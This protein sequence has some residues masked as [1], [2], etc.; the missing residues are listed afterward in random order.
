MPSS[1]DPHD[2]QSSRAQAEAT[3]TQSPSNSPAQGSETPETRRLLHELHVHQVELELQN[4]ELRRANNALDASRARYVDLYNLAPVGYCSVNE[5]GLIVQ[6]NL[7][8]AN[9]LGEAH[10]RL[11]GKRPFTN[12]VFQPDRDNWYL[13]RK[14]L[15][16]S[17]TP[18]TCELRL[19]QVNTGVQGG[20][21]A[22]VWVELSVTLAQDETG[23]RLLHIAVNDI[24][25]RKTTELALRQSG[26]LISLFLKY[27]PVHTFIKEVTST[28]SRVLGASD[29]FQ[30]MIGLEGKDMVGKTMAQL[31]PPEFAA[32]MSADDWTVVSRGKLVTL[33]EDLNGRSYTTIKFPI[34][35]AGRNLLAGFSIDITERK[36]EQDALRKQNAEL[37]LFNTAAVDR[38]LVMIGLKQEV[39]AL[40]RQLGLVAPY[41]VDFAD[42]QSKVPP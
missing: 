15:L 10:S 4:E 35:S 36:N 19:R 38:E 12:F 32:K 18:Q 33:E 26:E 6:A 5:A 31:F 21:S 24:N 30:Q 8:L 16:E 17:G 1:P 25:E 28:E 14:L 9:M 2:R 40:S 11:A 13:V 29:S 20:D 3:L 37:T 41:E 22:T 23:Q 7:T 34:A 27:T 39:N 42:T